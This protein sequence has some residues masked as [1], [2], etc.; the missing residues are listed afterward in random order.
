MVSP[1]VKDPIELGARIMTGSLGRARVFRDWQN[2]FAFPGD[3][4]YERYHFSSEGL[5]YICIFLEPY[6][7]SATCRS[8]ALTVPHTICIALRYLASGTFMYA[9]GNTE[10]LSKNTVCRVIHKVA[11]AITELLKAF[12]VF[13][14]HFSH[15]V[16][17]DLCDYFIHEQCRPSYIYCCVLNVN[18]KSFHNDHYC[19]VTSIEAKWSGSV[20]DSW[21]FR[22]TELSH[23]LEQSL[24]TT[25]EGYTCQPFLMTPPPDPGPQ[26]RLNVTLTKTRVRIEMTFGLLK[27][28]FTCLHG[29]TVACVVLHNIATIRR[30]RAA[31]VSQ[32]PPDVVDPITLDHPTGK[33]IREAITQQFFP[34][35]QQHFLLSFT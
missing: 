9:V 32:Q 2:P 29:I 3:H 28:R 17:I 4:L 11:H 35:K 6:I 8:N 34:K 19:I 14:E 31:P 20:H 15:A 33:A 25:L 5:T 21:I 26:N 24:E 23:R 16:D 13:P 10:S 27:A 30:E 7:T 22:E 18:R 1:F 12:V